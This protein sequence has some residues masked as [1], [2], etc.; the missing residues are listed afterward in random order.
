MLHITHRS[1]E[2]LSSRTASLKDSPSKA[3]ARQ[4]MLVVFP[5]PGGPCTYYNVS[6]KNL[7]VIILYTL[8]IKCGAI[9]FLMT[10]WSVV[11]DMISLF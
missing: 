1:L 11:Q 8:N 7:L 2:A 5:V 10:G 9:F 6:N 4:R 3:R